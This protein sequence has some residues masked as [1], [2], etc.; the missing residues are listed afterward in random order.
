MAKKII[1]TENDIV[2][3]VNDAALTILN[4]TSACLGVPYNYV[5]HLAHDVKSGDIEAIDNAANIMYRFV[6]KGSVLIPIP[7]HSGRA[8]YSLILSKFIGR[9]AKA[10]TIDLLS[11]DKRPRVFT[12]KKQGVN[13][14]DIKLDFHVE[15]NEEIAGYLAKTRNVILIDNV[16]DSGTTYEQ[17][18]MAIKNTYGVE[19]WLLTLGAVM[20]PKYDPFDV[21]RSDYKAYSE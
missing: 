1:L 16:I 7:Q 8:T 10:R 15:Y 3:I 21:I 5:R 14:S 18:R 19:P 13:P 20:N 9:K 4:E 17:A 12:L 11:T 6:P 2:N